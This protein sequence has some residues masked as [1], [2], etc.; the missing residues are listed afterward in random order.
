MEPKPKEAARNSVA[1]S[2]L[3]P[4]RIAGMLIWRP[5]AR[6]SPRP[7]RRHRRAERFLKGKLAF[8]QQGTSTAATATIREDHAGWLAAL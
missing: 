6:L 1:Q 3:S 4:S 2:L 5:V 8:N 7:S